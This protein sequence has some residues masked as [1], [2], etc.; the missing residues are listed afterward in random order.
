MTPNRTGT[1]VDVAGQARADAYHSLMNLVREARKGKARRYWYT[2][3]RASIRG[4]ASLEL[5]FVDVWPRALLWAQ[6][7]LDHYNANRPD[8]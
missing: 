6:C 5:E 1:L 8:L 4:Y 2:R 3:A 7:E